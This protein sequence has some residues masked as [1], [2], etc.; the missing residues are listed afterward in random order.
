MPADQPTKI[1]TGLTPGVDIDLRLAWRDVRGAVTADAHKVVVS[2]ISVSTEFVA[3]NTAAVG[4]RATAAVLQQLDDATDAVAD[5]LANVVP[6]SVIDQRISDAA[7]TLNSARASADSL[8]QDGIDETTARLNNLTLTDFGG[9]SSNLTLENV[10]DVFSQTLQVLEFVGTSSGGGDIYE[11]PFE[12]ARV[13]WT[14][15]GRTQPPTNPGAAYSSDVSFDGEEMI[16]DGSEQTF[17]AA[18]TLPLD[19]SDVDLVYTLRLRFKVDRLHSGGT[20][21][22]RILGLAYA[23][24]DDYTDPPTGV[25]SLGKFINDAPGADGYTDFVWSIGA[26]AAAVP[27]V[28]QYLGSDPQFDAAACTRLRFAFQAN[29]NNGDG[30][31]RLVGAYAHAGVDIPVPSS[32]ATSVIADLKQADAD[33]AV[34]LNSISYTDAS[35]TVLSLTIE[36]L[37]TGVA[38]RFQAVEAVADNANTEAGIARSESATAR[39][40]SAAARLDVK[41]AAGRGLQA[42]ND[43]PYFIDYPTTGIPT[44]YG[45]YQSAVITRIQNSQG[46]YI[47]R[48]DTP[49]GV[50]GGIVQVRN[51]APFNGRL[52]PGDYYMEADVILL[53][54]TLQG[55]GFG[56]YA[57][58]SSGGAA[59]TF[60]HHF[61]TMEDSSGE[62]VGS[63]VVGST[64]RFSKKVTITA[65]SSTR[66][67][68]YIFTHEFQGGP[69]GISQANAI[70]L[71]R[72]V[73]RPADS[74]EAQLTELREVAVDAQNRSNV[75]FQIV[76]QTPDGAFIIS[77]DAADDG[78]GNATSNLLFGA[79]RIDLVVFDQGGGVTSVVQAVTL[80]GPD[81]VFS[82]GINAA[83]VRVGTGRLN[84]AVEPVFA[85]GSDGDIISYGFTV[86]S[87]PK[88]SF[89]VSGL[90]ALAVGE[91]YVVKAVNRTSSQF[92]LSLKKRAAGGVVSTVSDSGAE[93]VINVD[94]G[95]G[96]AI[97]KTHND[98]SN[99]KYTFRLRGN[100]RVQSTE[101]FEIGQDDWFHS[102]FASINTYFN[103][104]G[105]YAQGPT[106]Y[107][108]PEDVGLDNAGSSDQTGDYAY[109]VTRTVDWGNAL[110]V[111]G[112]REFAV[113]LD[114]ASEI[115]TTVTE[116]VSVTYK[117]VSGASETSVSEDIEMSIQHYGSS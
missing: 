17:F 32:T 95:T 99:G 11:W 73:L 65:Q 59:Q 101:N 91:S 113:K 97:N 85:Q 58:N 54:G 33:Q 75:R 49:A 93:A 94:G 60:T 112:T 106:I 96:L 47:P 90:P 111:N 39:S 61:Y 67:N 3:G 71:E 110:G 55:A 45:N 56:L 51:S 35:S 48:I 80:E 68:Y 62:V 77:G 15:T 36:Q 63:G 115:G 19:A 66:Y 34:R 87:E 108:N 114:F 37:A 12:P 76:G 27:G 8:L 5:V 28:A 29:F 52:P 43:D 88:I 42:I 7:D 38:S 53:A 98:S 104:G 22:S 16:V 74:T 44:E 107:L 57:R 86:A 109:D 30:A 79:G 83:F 18:M 50:N 69:Q 46:A 100:L 24:E 70:A 21:G 117:N 41:L 40:E 102:G 13:N 9:S 25:S 89:D 105:G 82:G 92:M 6:S 23:L 81:A 78:N 2:D 31:M 1:I 14:R 84:V 116:L 20:V 103:S 64:Y 10:T 72:M 4:D 26:G